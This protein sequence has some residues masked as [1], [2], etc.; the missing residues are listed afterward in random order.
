[1]SGERTP[2]GRHWTHDSLPSRLNHEWT[3]GN[4]QQL[5]ASWDELNLTRQAAIVRAVLDHAVIAPGFL[6]ARTLDPDRRY[7]GSDGVVDEEPRACCRPAPA[8]PVSGTRTRSMTS[9]SV[10][11]SGSPWPG[12]Q[13]ERARARARWASQPLPPS[14]IRARTRA[15]VRGPFV[16]SVIVP[17]PG[18]FSTAAFHTNLMTVRGGATAGRACS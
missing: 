6:G 17:E 13:G 16:A 11:C 5:R 12:R 7:G 2:A 4:G 15:W 18:E 8:V 10:T 9:A 1:V 14:S 3:R